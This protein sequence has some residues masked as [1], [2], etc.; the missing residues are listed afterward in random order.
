MTVSLIDLHA[1]PSPVPVPHLYCHVITGGQNEWLRRMHC[2]RSDVI[3]MC[4]EGSDLLGSVVVIDSELEVIATANNPILARDEATCSDRD[5]GQF[6]S[7]D[8][9]LRFV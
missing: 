1:L 9:R 2:D 6:E 4:L 5:I 8:D 3:R 7:L